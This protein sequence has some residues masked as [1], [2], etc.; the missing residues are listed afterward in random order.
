VVVLTGNDR[1]KRGKVLKVFPGKNT[2]IVQG[3][4]FHKRHTKPTKMK[5]QGGILEKEGP[6]QL[7]NLKLICPKCGAPARTARTETVEGK[8]ERMCK[9]CGEII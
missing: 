8:N 7:S 2:A 5:Q 3:I 1:G 4:K 9:K 6:I